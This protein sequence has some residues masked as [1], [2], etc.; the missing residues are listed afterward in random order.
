MVKDILLVSN[1]E[2]YVL[3][4]VLHVAFWDAVEKR[5]NK[6]IDDP[7]KID[8]KLPGK[9]KQQWIELRNATA[10]EDQYYLLANKSEYTAK[11]EAADKTRDDIYRKIKKIVDAFAAVDFDAYAR[12][13]VS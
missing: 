6:F 9:L 3:Q 11:I 13:R 4:N 1:Y 8:E 2:T 7:N 12:S 10:T 5:V